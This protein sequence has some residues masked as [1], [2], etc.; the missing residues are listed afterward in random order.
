MKLWGA[1]VLLFLFSTVASAADK[2]VVD[3]GDL[4]CSL[5]REVAEPKPIAIA[6]RVVPGSG[7]AQ[8]L[9][10]SPE[11]KSVSGPAK[12]WL[13][14]GQVE[15]TGTAQEVSLGG[16]GQK[17]IEFFNLG[18]AFLDQFAGATSMRISKNNEVL[19]DLSFT[20][21]RAAV[22]ALRQCHD[23]VLRNWG[24]DPVAFASLRKLPESL[25][26]WITPDDYPNRA[27]MQNVSG[28]VVVRLTVMANGNVSDCK[29]VVS[30]GQKSLDEK[31]CEL[32]VR[33]ARFEPAI[34]FDGNA[35]AAMTTVAVTW[36]A[37]S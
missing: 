4:R 28:T 15:L 10:I 22:G 2:W 12:V 24:M 34:G 13:G 17:A 32:A 7:S 37:G 26:L 20:G 1:G 25:G 35:T 36:W 29:P 18:P 31:T 8:L 9:L 27:L 19:A 3:W 14:P 11:E 5:I 30:S 16:D 21:A 23:S 6:I 33:R